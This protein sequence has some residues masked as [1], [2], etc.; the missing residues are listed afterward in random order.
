MEAYIRQSAAQRGI[1][2]DIAV[3]VAKSEGLQK[4]TWQSNVQQP[5]GRERSYGPF[6]LHVAPAGSRPGMGNDFVN[7]TG[8]DP[9]DPKNAYAGIDFALD[10]AAKGGWSPW[11]GAKKVNVTGMQ[12]INGK[13]TPAGYTEP[14]MQPQQYMGSPQQ[15]PIVNQ[16]PGYAFGKPMG[17]DSAPQLYPGAQAAMASAEPG[18]PDWRKLAAGGPKTAF[19]RMENARIEHGDPSQ[20]DRLLRQLYTPAPDATP[21]ARLGLRA[22]LHKL[23]GVEESDTL[24]KKTGWLGMGGSGGNGGLLSGLFSKMFG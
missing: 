16:Q 7:A 19:Q 10:Q 2:P 24:K 20:R 9:S 17:P 4:G 22:Q 18:A 8:L 21:A 12:G 1:D 5:Y 15:A 3:K 13:Y 6:Q 11:F 14:A 23:A